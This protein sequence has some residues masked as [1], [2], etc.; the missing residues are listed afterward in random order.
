MSWQ[1]RTE[2]V[3]GQ[4]NI[5]KLAK[6]HVL[7]VGLGGIGGFAAEAIA[8]SGVGTMTIVDGDTVDPSNRNRQI[9]AL[10]STEGLYKSDILETRLKDIN[11][12]LKIIKHTNFLEEKEI[13]ALLDAAPYDYVVDC[14]D[15]IT[16]K[17][18]L[19][20]K[21]VGRKLK[22]V[23]A[24][25]A[26]GK[27]DP[28]Q[29]KIAR[30]RDTYNCYLSKTVRKQIPEK[31]IRR[32]VKVVFSPENIDKSKVH[33]MPSKVKYKRSVIGTV[34]YMPAIFGLNC[35]SV[36]IRDLIK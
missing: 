2:L 25:G 19:I 17:V 33:E 36:V 35:A 10:S 5:D 1:E 30:L 28:S 16:P 27:V 8:R 9:I 4:K 3:L 20:K 11:P 15:T 18:M 24:M 34:S 7:V 13:E 29:T 14:I 26:G 32:K 12:D 21:A 31:S 22:V 6:A 23:S